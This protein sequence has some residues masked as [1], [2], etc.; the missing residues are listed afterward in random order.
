MNVKPFCGHLNAQKFG[1]ISNK[2]GAKSA[3]TQSVYTSNVALQT[4]AERYVPFPNSERRILAPFRKT[5][6]WK[7]SVCKRNAYPL[8]DRGCNDTDPVQCKR[9]LSVILPKIMLQS[10]QRSE[11][12]PGYFIHRHASSFTGNF[13]AIIEYDE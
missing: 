3:T 5:Q 8:Q 9:S 10:E 2:C 6:R 4:H 13:T 7:R 12:E 11:L 1:P